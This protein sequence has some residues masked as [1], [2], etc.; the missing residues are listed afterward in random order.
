MKYY[1]SSGELV[2]FDGIK[3]GHYG[4]N[5]EIMRLS[6][7]SVYKKYFNEAEDTNH[8]TLEV[9]EFIKLLNNE[10]MVKLIERFYQVKNNL[11]ANDIISAPERYTIDVYTYE[12]VKEDNIDILNMPVDYLLDNMNELL[13]LVDYL[14]A[15]GLYM[16]D[17]MTD[18]AVLNE[19]GIVLI[20]PDIY[21]FEYN[22]SYKNFMMVSDNF[23]VKKWN[24]KCIVELL[25]RLCHRSLLIRKEYDRLAYVVNEMFEE[26]SWT[27]E[28]DTL[29][30]A[31][32]LKGYST[33]KEYI[34]STKG[35]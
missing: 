30:V 1:N 16:I 14:S 8:I 4:Q 9:F 12:W 25:K 7:G 6:D 19:N 35:R 10:H 31:N 5:S 29:I 20:D 3:S 18:N 24:R 27:G 13:H 26:V 34:Y 11:K 15:F 17:V 33:P 21:T 22:T 28:Y 2:E 23:R 32:K